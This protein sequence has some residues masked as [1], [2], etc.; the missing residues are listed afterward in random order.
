MIS[1]LGGFFG[2]LMIVLNTIANTYSRYD[3][4]LKS[5]KSARKETARNSK[6]PSES[7][8]SERRKSERSEAASE[9]PRNILCPSVIQN[10]LYTYINEKM[11]TEKFNLQVDARF[12]R[13]LKNLPAPLELNSIRTLKE[14]N[15]SVFR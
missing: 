1:I 4:P 3:R 13:F 2:Q 11:K 15:Y 12:E 8:K 9:A 14:P 7:G 10:F 5:S 6:E